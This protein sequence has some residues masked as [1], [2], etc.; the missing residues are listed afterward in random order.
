MKTR[1]PCSV[2][3]ATHADTQPLP[4]L[5]SVAC[6]QAHRSPASPLVKQK[7]PLLWHFWIPPRRPAPSRVL[8]VHAPIYVRLCPNVTFLEKPSQDHHIQH[9]LPFPILPPPPCRTWHCLQMV[10]IFTCWPVYFVSLL[11]WKHRL[12]RD[13][14]RLI[15]CCMS[16]TE[17]GAQHVGRT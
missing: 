3:A 15:L 6:I 5:V 8:K 7:P 11:K 17:N 9:N 4:G 13:L 16:M 10:P 14:T 1:V 2:H 12:D